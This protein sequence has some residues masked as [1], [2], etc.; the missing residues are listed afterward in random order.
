MTTRA[1]TVGV[2]TLGCRLNQVES[3]EM[4]GLVEAQGFRPVAG[5]ERAEVYVVNTCTVTG[6][7]DFSDRQ[8]IR[9]IA[10]ERPGALV[11]VTGCWA[12]TDPQA[13]ARIPGVDL[14]L[15]NQEKYRLPELLAALLAR[16]PSPAPA[17]GWTPEIEVAPIAE[18]R[19]VPAAPLARVAG[20][21][22]AFVK[23]QDGCQHRCAFCVVPL[24]RGGSR[25]QEPKVVV[26]QVH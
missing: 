21:S 16:R 8:L 20:R 18:A 19:S 7:A 26:D 11:V 24:A 15:G 6:R 9:R 5:A 23:I 3:Q 1:I 4:L 13:V 22:R 25:S 12:Q 14:V 17:D 10:R 2:A